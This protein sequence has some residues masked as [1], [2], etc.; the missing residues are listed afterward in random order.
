[1]LLNFL[2]KLLFPN[3]ADWQ[4]QKDTK[5]MLLVVLVSVIFASIVVVV[6]LFINGQR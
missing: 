4:R 6:M 2:A 3:Q 5:V 1:M